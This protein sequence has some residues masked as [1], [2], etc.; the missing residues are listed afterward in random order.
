MQHAKST[1]KH[2]SSIGESESVKEKPISPSINR[3]TLKNYLRYRENL[4]DPTKSQ[5]RRQQNRKNVT[6]TTSI[7]EPPLLPLQEEEE[8]KKQKMDSETMILYLET[9]SDPIEAYNQ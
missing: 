7:Y 5:A 3:I 1:Q 4:L 9:V 8:I 2:I 6:S